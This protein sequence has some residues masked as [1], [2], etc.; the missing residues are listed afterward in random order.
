MMR[1]QLRFAVHGIGVLVFA[2]ALGSGCAL[3]VDTVQLQ[4][5]AQQGVA[6][7]EG[8]DKVT[9]AVTLTDARTRKDRVSSKKNGYGMEMAAIVSKEDV[10]TLVSTAIA[11]ELRSRGFTVAESRVTVGIELTKFWNDF[12]TG[13][14]SGS[15]VGEVVC[16]VQVKKP[17][18]NINYVK[19][20][21]GSY[22]EQHIQLA[23]GPNAKNAL[24]GALKD[25]VTKLMQDE[26]FIKAI[27]QAAS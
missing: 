6:R 17:D 3:T 26:N 8:A 12:K 11:V 5:L 27:L 16:N 4:Y 21:T 1:K 7:I 15:A 19:S 2:A 20:I 24:D 13:F 22:T 14:W 23:S 18:G 10:A 9:V 25:A